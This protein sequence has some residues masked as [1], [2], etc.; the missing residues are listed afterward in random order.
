M[1]D[2]IDEKFRKLASY[3][4]GFEKKLDLELTEMEER[5][6]SQNEANH[7][8]EMARLQQVDQVGYSHCQHGHG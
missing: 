4:Q 3:N 7:S 6:H 8:A 2:Q 1:K 5:L